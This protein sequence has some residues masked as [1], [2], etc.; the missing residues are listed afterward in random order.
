MGTVTS[1]KSLNGNGYFRLV[2][3]MS[4]AL[5][6]RND[7]EGPQRAEVNTFSWRNASF[8]KRVRF[9]SGSHSQ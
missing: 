7:P 4:T 6:S 5:M 1:V 2:Q 8:S 3:C 9:S